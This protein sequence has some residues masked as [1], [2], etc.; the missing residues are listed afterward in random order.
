M[1]NETDKAF[2]TDNEQV[3]LDAG[4]PGLGSAHEELVPAP[5]TPEQVE[6]WKQQAGKAQENWDRLVRVS[7]DFDNYKKRAA[8][9]RQDAVR[10]A[11]EG[12]LEKL[13]PIVDNLEAALNAANNSQA[14]AAES[15][16]T[17]VAMIQSQL[18]SVLKDAGLE[19]IEASG[20]KFDPNWHEAVSEQVVPNVPE[21]QVVQQIRK[22]FKLKD[23]LLRPASVVVSKKPA[24]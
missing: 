3:P 24:A 10:F 2:A 9:E 7:A 14:N 11:N 20:Q 4:E 21:G 18:R 6:E 22:G 13:I 16:K 23:R 8:R 5:N 1:T 17:G 12:L 15:L 19:E